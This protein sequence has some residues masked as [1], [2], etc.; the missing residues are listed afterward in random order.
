MLG[1]FCCRRRESLQLEHSEDAEPNQTGEIFTVS[2]R[3]DPPPP[4]TGR[5]SSDQTPP[6]YKDVVLSR[7]TPPPPP[8]PVFVG[9][10]DSA[11]RTIR[12]EDDDGGAPQIVFGRGRP[13]VL[14]LLRQRTAALCVY[15]KQKVHTRKLNIE[16]S[17]ERTTDERPQL[18]SITDP[19]PAAANRSSPAAERDFSP[20]SL[21]AARRQEVRLESADSERRDP[22]RHDPVQN[23]A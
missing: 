12:A 15:L 3:V 1:M 17:S 21:K 18:R 9:E 14:D 20:S 6:R 23:L 11:G 13:R 10:V 2:S 7:S 8:P 16:N 22:V 19:H 4:V 5:P